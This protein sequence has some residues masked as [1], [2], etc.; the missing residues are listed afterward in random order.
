MS[1][2]GKRAPYKQLQRVDRAPQ[3]RMAVYGGRKSLIL[4]IRY[5]AVMSKCG[6][7]YGSTS[8]RKTW[9]GA[10]NAVDCQQRKHSG[11]SC[12]QDFP[13]YNAM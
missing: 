2:G 8:R 4:V 1:D 12:S 5:L 10:Q 11:N 6:K 3:H 13:N 7:R 9:S